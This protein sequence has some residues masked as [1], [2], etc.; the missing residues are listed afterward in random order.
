MLDGVKEGC[1][2]EIL[3]PFSTGGKI[4]LSIFDFS[5]EEKAEALERG[6]SKN[7]FKVCNIFIFRFQAGV[8]MIFVTKIYGV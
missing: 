6:I 2:K 3:S 1:A 7:G 8:S 4:Q 5:R